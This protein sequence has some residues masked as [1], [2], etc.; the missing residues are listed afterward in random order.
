M[1]LLEKQPAVEA[2]TKYVL[3][4]VSNKE[5]PALSDY[6]D[7]LPEEVTHNNLHRSGSD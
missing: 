7:N 1:V 2:Y 4:N 6:N 3:P 5:L